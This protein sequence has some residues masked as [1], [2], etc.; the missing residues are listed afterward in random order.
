MKICK[1]LCLS[2][3]SIHKKFKKTSLRLS[4]DRNFKTGVKYEGQVINYSILLYIC[5]S[6]HIVNVN[7]C[8]YVHLHFLFICGWFN[9]CD[10]LQEKS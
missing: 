2:L 10:C 4:H 1:D 5:V 8:A 9:I 7:Y 6:I 3:S